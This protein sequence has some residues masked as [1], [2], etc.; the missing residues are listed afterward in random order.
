MLIETATMKP[1]EE[2][3]KWNEDGQSELDGSGREQ[4]QLIQMIPLDHPIKAFTIKS[5]Y[6]LDDHPTIQPE[7]IQL[8]NI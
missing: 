5:N 6:Q 3:K 4:L 8:I 2:L 1:L 7:D